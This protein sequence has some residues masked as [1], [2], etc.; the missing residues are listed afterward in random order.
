MWWNH[1]SCGALQRLEVGGWPGAAAILHTGNVIAV[2]G[3]QLLLDAVES[4]RAAL[5]A[6]GEHPGDH[7]AAIP[8]GDWAVAHYFDS[9]IPG[10]Q[11]WQWCV[12][13]AGSPANDDVTISETALL[14]A[15]GALLAPDWVPWSQ[16]V[17]SGDLTP[18]DVLAAEDDDPRLVP[19]Q[20]DTGDEFLAD[21]D[22][23]AQVAGELGL[24]RRRVLS[25]EGR[26]DAA[27]RWYD[28]DFGPESEMAQA[29]PFSC[30]TCG[31]YIPLSGALR[32]AFGACANELA[33]DG[34]VV[35]A[36]YGCGAHSDVEP[37]RGEGSPAYE[38]FD[39]GVLEIV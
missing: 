38:A 14:P 8:E 16:R 37:H 39:D 27:Q 3:N 17:E 12:V 34:R 18:G 6:D 21:D 26:D 30:G 32:A 31:F 2:T 7:R 19:N 25:R 28:G 5:E 4:A 10:Y 9:D 35:S 29:A 23:V 20:I 22:D 33:A 15:D 13:V 1:R 36:E 11:G 24:G